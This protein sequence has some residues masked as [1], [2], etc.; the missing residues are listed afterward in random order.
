MNRRYFLGSAT[1]L[2]LA[3]A[4]ASSR[5]ANFKGEPWQWTAREL[6]EAIR[7]REISVREATQSTLSRL[8]AVN[9]RI[10]AVVAEMASEALRYADAAD[11][12]KSGRGVLHGI[13]VTIKIN[14]DQK[15]HAT[16]HGARY[17]KGNVASDDA[18]VVA[19]FRKAGAILIG[20]TNCPTFSFRWFTDCDAHGRTLN[21]YG[22][23]LTPGGSSGGGSAAVAVGI[24]P[25]GHGSDLG[26]SVRYPAY[27]CG[28]FGLRPTV[29]RAPRYQPTAAKVPA[30]LVGQLFS[31][32]G[33]FARSVDDL[34][35]SLA[36][37]AQGDRRDPVWSP[38]PL[39]VPASKS[40]RRA[41]IMSMGV[42]G[43]GL[44][45]LMKAA[46]RLE[47][48]GY[49][50]EE[51]PLPHYEEAAD[52]WGRIVLNESRIGLMPGIRK[53][54]DKAA[55]IAA[56][57]MLELAPVIELGSYLDSFSRRLFIQRAWTEFFQK[58]PVVL[59][60]VS[61]E[62]PFPV[63]LDQSLEGMRRIFMAQQPLFGPVL[64]GVPALA[65]PTG[66]MNGAPTGIQIIA[67][68]FRE[69]LCFAA[70]T[71]I[72]ATQPVISPTW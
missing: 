38:Q 51:A 5:A 30:S 40:A 21:P 24:G 54:G 42:K 48:A 53:S 47:A 7:T 27:A 52:L 58:F 12:Q 60:P 17:L 55:I 18:A 23:N 39:S 68:R 62:P 50:V 61:L 45:A 20:R 10:N 72:T 35:L 65:V 6:A 49:T 46:L 16:T 33:L 3:M 2:P 15:G 71:A 14:T 66:M 56:E 57:A 59:S 41:A 70:A 26:G 64:A 63:D 34:R 69:D 4:G 13:P 44:S 9:P 19:N 22:R 11:R 32:D 1:A 25:I 8:E 43:S 29:G 37:M 31:V 67:D 36:A 28:V